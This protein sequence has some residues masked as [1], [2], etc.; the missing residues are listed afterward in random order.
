MEDR[1][2]WMYGL[3]RYS[4]VYV[5]EVDKFITVAVNHAKTLS[6]WTNCSIIYPY[7]DCKNHLATYDV[8]TS[9]HI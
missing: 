6:A 8:E 1:V 9:Y 7:K 4:Q 2:T 3:P 5:D